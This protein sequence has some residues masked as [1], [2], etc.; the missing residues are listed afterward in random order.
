LKTYSNWPTYPQLFVN[1]DLVGGCDIMMEMVQ[2][3][4][5]QQLLQDAAGAPAGGAA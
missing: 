5:L 4:S 3:G 1:G 2:D